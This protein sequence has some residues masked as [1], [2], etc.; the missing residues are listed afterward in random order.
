M[1]NS[2]AMIFRCLRIWICIGLG[3]GVQHVSYAQNVE[4]DEKDYIIY[5]YGNSENRFPA[6]SAD[7]N[8]DGITDIGNTN[9]DCRIYKGLGNDEFK[10]LSI[11]LSL[12]FVDWVDLNMDGYLDVVGQR[13]I[14]LYDTRDTFVSVED[15]YDWDREF[16]PND[17]LIVG[18]ADFD[19]NGYQDALLKVAD[20]EDITRGKIC[21]FY[22]D[23]S[24][25]V[26][27]STFILGDDNDI[28]DIDGDGWIDIVTRED[29]SS[30]I[31]YLFN[32]GDGDF[33]LK[34]N[35]GGSF[36]GNSALRLADIDNDGDLDLAAIT[37]SGFYLYE[38]TG[39]VEFDRGSEILY[40]NAP[41]FLSVGDVDNDGN[42]DL[43]IGDMES[44]DGGFTFTEFSIQV[45]LGNG[46][47]TFLEPEII[48]SG[49]P[50]RQ[51]LIFLQMRYKKNI[52]DL[53]DYNNDGLL[54]IIFMDG[55]KSNT[56][57]VPFINETEPLSN[58]G[59]QF[60]M[61]PVVYPNPS[62]EVMRVAGVH[63][64]DYSILNMDGKVMDAGTVENGE[65]G[66]KD[67]PV[68]TYLLHIPALDISEKIVK[69]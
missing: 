42:L 15:V 22:E 51:G 39:D 35:S 5:Q 66:V 69:K 54:D 33:E 63:D 53:Y 18:M 23:S 27:D 14:Y 13:D 2:I 49:H 68:G 67:L 17:Y 25:M 43:V 52:L 4:F 36:W 16:V 59:V 38:F 45:L 50:Y 41:A 26:Q 55:R 46:D 40:S 10:E 32:T 48:Y 7:F 62:T 31:H 3:L 20:Q 29:A 19:N 11:P 60:K 30:N 44:S 34:T 9:F 61:S 37:P 12:Y 28:G 65:V 21:Y 6:Y 64:V 47:N 1:Q 57:I 24:Y 56:F 8:A 58:D